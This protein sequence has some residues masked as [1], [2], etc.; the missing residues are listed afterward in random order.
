MTEQCTCRVTPRERFLNQSCPIHGDAEMH[1]RHEAARQPTKPI[2]EMTDDEMEREFHRLFEQATP[3]Q[4]QR[5]TA[6]IWDA[7]VMAAYKRGG[8][9]EVTRVTNELRE[10]RSHA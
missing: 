7:V 9:A 4:R 1:R 10:G 5:A 6:L 8:A 3:E 2:E